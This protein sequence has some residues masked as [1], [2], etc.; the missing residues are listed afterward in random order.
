MRNPYVYV[1]TCLL[2]FVL[3]SC[4]GS[5]PTQDPATDVSG[6]WSGQL[7]TDII[8]L[9]FTMSLS[10]RDTSL[11]G[12]LALAD[13]PAIPIS[14]EVVNN[15]IMLSSGY[16]DVNLEILGTVDND[17]MTGVMALNLL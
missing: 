16:Q 6:D 17:T 11:T 7:T 8:P 9:P 3:T 2:A 12:T 14:G 15:R 4:G 5:G 10:Q 13:S 1:I